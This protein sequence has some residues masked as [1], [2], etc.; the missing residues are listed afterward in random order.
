MSI[1]VDLIIIIIVLLSIF[2]GYKQGLIKAAIKIASFF[3]AIAVAFMLYQP[4]ANAIINNTSIDENIQSSITNRILPEGATPDSEVQI[5][6]IPNAILS[7]AANTVNNISHAL[8]VKIIEAVVLLAIYVVVRLV[9]RLVTVLA[10]L[11]A[12]IPILK[13]FNE[14]RRSNI[15]TA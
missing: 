13:Q 6:N 15:W 8:T 3:I 11:I 9:L 4:V 10:D 12:K 2:L 14:L 7:G 5:T 1:A